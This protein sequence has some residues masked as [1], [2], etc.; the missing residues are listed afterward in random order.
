MN[1]LSGPL[2]R[3]GPRVTSLDVSTNNLDG[4]LVVG[5]S[6]P[7]TVS[8]LLLDGNNFSGPI[9]DIGL[10]SDLTIFSIEHNPEVCGASPLPMVGSPLLSMY[11]S[12]AIY[13]GEF[14]HRCNAVRLTRQHRTHCA[15]WPSIERTR[16]GQPCAA[17]ANDQAP[18]PGVVVPPP[19]SVALPAAVGSRPGAVAAAPVAVTVPIPDRIPRRPQLQQPST[20]TSS[21]STSASETSLNSAVP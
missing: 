2:P 14:Q 4:P 13:E 11:T 7:I 21:E 18:G 17:S 19:V 9:L 3:W 20:T 6:V 10:C 16:I 15:L 1:R 5:Q 12:T 8:R